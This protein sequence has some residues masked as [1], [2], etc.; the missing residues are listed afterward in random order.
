MKFESKIGTIKKSEVEVFNFL[1]NFKNIDRLIPENKIN[2]WESTENSCKFTIDMAGE[3]SIKIIEKE[4]YKTI[5]FSGEANNNQISFFFWIQLKEINPNDTKV[6]LTLKAELPPM[7]Q[8]MAKKP[9]QE[10]LNMLVD[11]FD[12]IFKKVN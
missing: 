5:K 9:I 3:I 7:I 12:E 4:P 10:G 11:R 8:M 6:K 1:S 2:N